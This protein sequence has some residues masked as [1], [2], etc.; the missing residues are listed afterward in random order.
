MYIWSIWL[1]IQILYSLTDIDVDNQG[2]NIEILAS[3]MYFFVSGNS[4]RQL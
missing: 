3:P 2:Q 1:E 4:P